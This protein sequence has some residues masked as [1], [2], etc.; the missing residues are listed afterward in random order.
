VKGAILFDWGGTLMRELPKYQGPMCLWPR[1]EAMPGAQEVLAALHPDWQLAVA[2]N[3]VA[4]DERQIWLALERA[5]LATYL[6]RVFC[7]RS[8]GHKKPSLAFY[9]SCLQ[10]LKLPPERVVM[11]GD[12]FDA[13]VLGATDA[14]L[15]AIWLN[16][17]TEEAREGER[18]RTVHAPRDLQDVLAKL[19]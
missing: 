4:S 8:I 12:D 9:R 6:S 2:T 10:D 1:V 18:Y 3:A 17:R 19:L 13:D 5:G 15:F 7:F 14:G 16:E 11:V